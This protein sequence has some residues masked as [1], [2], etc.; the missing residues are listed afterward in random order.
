MDCPK[1]AALSYTC[2][3]Q[4][5]EGTIFFPRSQDV[6][7]E[8]YENLFQAL[9]QALYVDDGVEWMWIDAICI[10]QGD[11]EEREDQVAKMYDI[12]KQSKNVMVWLGPA[13]NNATSLSN[14]STRRLSK[15][16]TIE[17][18]QTSMSRTGNWL[19]NTSS[20]GHIGQEHGSDGVSHTARA[21]FQ[22]QTTSTFLLL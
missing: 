22:P 16:T 12:Y 13:A 11:L 17:T 18:T 10:N 15:P 6:D 14:G 20:T 5:E 8:R 1:Y 7:D 2:G 9:R 21:H 19:W 3:D 4:S